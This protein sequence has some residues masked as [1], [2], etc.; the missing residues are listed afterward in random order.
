[1]A[2]NVQATLPVVWST[3]RQARPAGVDGGQLAWARDDWALRNLKD[4]LKAVTEARVTYGTVSGPVSDG[5]LLFSVVPSCAWAG[6]RNGS[7]LVFGVV[8]SCT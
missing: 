1:M 5:G 7:G 4:G 2:P 6:F 8:R 3:P